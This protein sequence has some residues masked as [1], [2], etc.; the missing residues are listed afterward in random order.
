MRIYD[1]GIY[2]DATAEEIAEMYVPDLISYE[3]RV[4]ARIRERYSIGQEFA[5]QRQRDT[6]P[7]E[8]AEYFA[9]VEQ[10]KAEER[11]VQ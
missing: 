10:I 9:F 6:K 1:N 3:E 4:E 11:E 8:F 5:V 2:R 7:E